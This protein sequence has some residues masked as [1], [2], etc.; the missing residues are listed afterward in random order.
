MDTVTV[1]FLAVGVLA[2]LLIG[3]FPYITLSSG[4]AA[5]SAAI[6]AVPEPPSAPDPDDLTPAQLGFLI[7]GEVRAAEVA[8]TDA[9]LSGRV[10]E[11]PTGGLRVRG[12]VRPRPEEGDPLR[13]AILR[14]MSPLGYADTRTVVST[15]ITS[16]GMRGLRVSLRGRRL[17]VDSPEVREHLRRC[18]L[19]PRVSGRV[20]LASLIPALVGGTVFLLAGPDTAYW[21]AAVAAGG[22]AAAVASVSVRWACT[23]AGRLS[24]SITTRT[25]DAVVTEAKRRY[26][27]S[28][29]MSLEQALRYTAVTGFLSLRAGATSGG[30]APARRRRRRSS[31]H[32]G[33]AAGAAI[34]AGSPP[35]RTFDLANLC[36]SAE[37]CQ[38][39]SN[40][41]IGSSIRGGDGWGGGLDTGSGGGGGGGSSSGWFGGGGE[42]GGGGFSGGGSG[43]GGGGGG[44]AGGGAVI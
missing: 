30:R 26:T 15:L 14:S 4:R 42:S 6:E 33:S 39:S 36:W 31:G 27:L 38:G 34:T 7:G 2:G 11:R 32:Q 12:R 10:S 21:G 3:S 9:L 43:G 24:P 22:V 44:D 23:A 28:D 40:S 18:R 29:A 41:V 25:G 16:G 8:L 17:I 37:L 35:P 20:T 13:R 1:L 19:V 5:I